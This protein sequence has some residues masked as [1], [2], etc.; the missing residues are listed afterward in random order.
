MRGAVIRRSPPRD[1]SARYA[2]RLIAAC[3]IIGAGLYGTS[4][5]RLGT[6]AREPEVAPGALGS[7]EARSTTTVESTRELYASFHRIARGGPGDA[8]SLARAL[9]IARAMKGVHSR[10]VGARLL[11]PLYFARTSS[12]DDVWLAA[13][14]ITTERTSNAAR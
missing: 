11:E 9:R 6:F 12:V 14:S 10:S 7:F 5:A 8:D 3:A 13:R 2:R 4:A 1:H